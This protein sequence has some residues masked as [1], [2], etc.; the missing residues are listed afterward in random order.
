MKMNLAQDPAIVDHNPLSLVLLH[1]SKSYDTID[2]DRRIH[3]LE[4]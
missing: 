1:L 2:R 4:G 3:T